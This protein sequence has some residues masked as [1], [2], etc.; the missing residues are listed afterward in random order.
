[1]FK[2]VIYDG[3]NNPIKEE[4][5]PTYERAKKAARFYAKK[6]QS[7]WCAVLYEEITYFWVESNG[8]EG[9][10]YMAKVKGLI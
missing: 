3:Y 8:K 5:R 6:G 2:V 9:E 10:N 4:E 1:M 7:I